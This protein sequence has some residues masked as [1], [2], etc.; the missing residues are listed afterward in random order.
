MPSG[1]KGHELSL[2]GKSDS[3]HTLSMLNSSSSF[4]PMRSL[5]KQHMMLRLKIS[6][7]DMPPGNSCIVQ[8]EWRSW[9][10][11]PRCNT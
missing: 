2:C 4:T 3:Q 1:P 7:G 10:C 8:P 6:V 5:M 11:S 9:M